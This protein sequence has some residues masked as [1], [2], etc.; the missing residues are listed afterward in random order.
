[1]ETKSKYNIT[2]R[3][4]AAMNDCYRQYALIS[5]ELFVFYLCFPIPFQMTTPWRAV[6]LLLTL[7]LIL[8]SGQLCD[9]Q[10]S[11]VEAN[12]RFGIYLYQR[13]GSGSVGSNMI[14]SPWSVSAAL[15]MTYGGANGATE[16][17]ME[18]ALRFYGM[19]A[20]CDPHVGF[21]SLI[22]LL[23]GAS[24]INT[25]NKIFIDTSFNLLVSSV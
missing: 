20:G 17:Q 10:E 19:A 23:Q 5:V 8:T 16:L 1:M 14:I 22:N 15:A 21:H 25:A 12:S 3:F 11:V 13:I 6:A 7:S 18:Q 9:H 24:T 2:L 4:F